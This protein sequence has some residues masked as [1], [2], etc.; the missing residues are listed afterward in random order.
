[1]LRPLLRCIQDE[2]RLRHSHHLL[3]RCWF[4]PQLPTKTGI[5]QLERNWAASG[6]Y[7]PA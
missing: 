7:C 6:W 3:Y 2:S 4:Y 5:S 1:L